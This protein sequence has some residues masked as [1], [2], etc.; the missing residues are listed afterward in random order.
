MLKFSKV[1][2]VIGLSVTSLF[3]AEQGLSE[4][5]I[6]DQVFQSRYNAETNAQI[7]KLKVPVIIEAS[8]I[9]VDGCGFAQRILRGIAFC[10]TSFQGKIVQVAPQDE[11]TAGVSAESGISSY[12]NDF[13][14]KKVK[15]MVPLSKDNEEIFNK[16]L[17]PVSKEYLYGVSV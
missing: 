12:G 11:W 14:Y 8:N 1:A 5:E 6:F 10:T 2:L 3:A 4:Q 15:H 7:T 17:A 13:S 16:K 9:V